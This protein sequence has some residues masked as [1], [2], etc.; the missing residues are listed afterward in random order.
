V[1]NG[2]SQDALRATNSLLTRVRKLQEHVTAT[3]DELASQIEKVRGKRLDVLDL[4]LVVKPD[5]LDAYERT[6]DV[7]INFNPRWGEEGAGAVRARVAATRC[8][9]VAERIAARD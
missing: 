8:G 5:R 1:S 6:L 9:T 2:Q 3:A 4:Q 7:A